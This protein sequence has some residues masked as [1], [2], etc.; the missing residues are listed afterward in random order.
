MRNDPKPVSLDGEF[1][2]VKI[3][4]FGMFGG[5]TFATVVFLYM[6]TLM[7]EPNE[8]LQR[9]APFVLGI[10]VLVAVAGRLLIRRRFIEWVRGRADG[11]K[12]IGDPLTIPEVMTQYRAYAIVSAGLM[13]GPGLF[14]GV[15]YAISGAAILLIVPA[16]AAL[17]FLAEPPTE[18]GAR[19]FISRVIERS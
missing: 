12:R 6:A 19:Q 9:I 15:F 13:E 14:A 17:V 11:L 7:S 8:Q 1:R 18:D 10:L 4:W 3:I 2:G 16:M 5:L